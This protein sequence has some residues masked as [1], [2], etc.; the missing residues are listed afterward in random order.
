[1]R[2]GAEGDRDDATDALRRIRANVDETLLILREDGATHDYS[3]H[4]HEFLEAVRSRTSPIA[5]ARDVRL[6]IGGMP[7]GQVSGRRASL[8]VL[9]VFNLV[10]NACDASAPGT[11][12]H[13]RAERAGDAV[14]LRVEDEAGGLPPEIEARPFEPSTSRKAGGAGLGLVITRQLVRSAGGVVE[15]ERLPRGT[16]FRITV[17]DTLPAP[18]P[19]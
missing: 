19:P 17:P 7:G 2:G 13:V 18:T 10:E 16:V 6:D 11:T 12:V 15:F 14:V 3:L 4:W 8:L 9:A 1:V 5:A